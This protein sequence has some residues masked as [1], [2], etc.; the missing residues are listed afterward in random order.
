MLAPSGIDPV[1]SSRLNERTFDGTS[2]SLAVAVKVTLE[3]SSTVWS[4]IGSR[5]G[6]TLTSLTVIV[7]VSQTGSAMPS[8]TQ[9]SKV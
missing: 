6:A 1:P 3:P 2:T 4:L 5:T 7:T 8:L 9:T